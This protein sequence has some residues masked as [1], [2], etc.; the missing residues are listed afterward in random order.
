MGKEIYNILDDHVFIRYE[1]DRYSD[2][3][4]VWHGTHKF[5][6]S[7]RIMNMVN[8]IREYGYCG[9]K[10]DNSRHMI[11]VSK[12]FES[13][14][15]NDPDGY[16]LKTRKHRAAACIALGLKNVRVKI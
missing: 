13:P 8:S 6:A 14:Y 11:R 5:N 10:F 4:S 12:G 7:K 15:G 1:N 9:G 3:E 2:S 16:T